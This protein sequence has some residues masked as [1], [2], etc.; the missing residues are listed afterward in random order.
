LELLTPNLDMYEAWLAAHAEWGPGVHEDGFGLTSADDVET[1]AGFAQWVRRLNAAEDHCACRSIV[2]DGRVVGG[3]A[4][5]LEDNDF[6]R[7]HGHVGYGIRPSARGRHVAA[8][9]LERVLD[10]ARLNG[11]N[12]VLAVCESGNVA[13]ARTIERLGGTLDGDSEVSNIRRYWI[14]LDE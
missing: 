8:W 4:L 2:E 6:I 12:R 7:D 1:V 3:I 13:S 14:D 10:L 11:M 9:A 5:R